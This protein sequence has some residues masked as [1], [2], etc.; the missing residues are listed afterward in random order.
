MFLDVLVNKRDIG[1]LEHQL[2]RKTLT[3]TFTEIPTTVQN[4]NENFLKLSLTPRNR[5]LIKG[6]ESF[7]ECLPSQRVFKPTSKTNTTSTHKNPDQQ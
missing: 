5:P 6:T 2:Y 4:E 3:T 1:T 7:R